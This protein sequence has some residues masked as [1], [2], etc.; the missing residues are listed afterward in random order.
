MTEGAR[1]ASGRPLRFALKTL[2]CKVNQAESESLASSLVGA[3]AVFGT[4]DEADVVIVNTCTVTG[5]ATAKARKAI[6]HSLAG[7]CSPIVVVTGCL[8]VVDSESLLAISDRVVVEPDK[9]RLAHL[10]LERMRGLDDAERRDSRD[11]PEGTPQ[12]KDAD[13]E[14]AHVRRGARTRALVKIQDGCDAF[15]TYC[16]VPHAR[17]GPRSIPADDLVA[18]V[19]SLVALGVQ[20]VVLTGINL[21]GYA[22]RGVGLAALVR[23][24]AGSGIARL[25]LSSIEPLDMTDEL[26]GVFADNPACCRHLHVPLQ[27]GDDAVL[28]AMSRRYT[29]DQYLDRVDSARAALPGVAITTD[30]MVGFPGETERQAQ[31]TLAACTTA[32]FARLHVFRFSRRQGT[33]AADMPDQVAPRTKANRAVALR[34]LD[35]R[36]RSAHGRSAIGQTRDV[37]LERLL[38]DGDIAEGTSGD[39]LRVRFRASADVSV[40]DVV[41]VRVLQETR[42]GVAGVLVREGETASHGRISA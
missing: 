22:H 9:T 3:G 41:D 1:G 8:A 11:L 23:E 10:A 25:R 5:E 34:E 42:S 27:S 31:H 30:V 12:A 13:V 26:L 40:G 37:L 4:A 2:G 16:I 29:L 24:L 18:Q 7:G 14:Q 38:G 6:R 28:A 15:C 39:Y 21:G 33:V 36:L 35:A 32:G 19:T 17:G 20:E